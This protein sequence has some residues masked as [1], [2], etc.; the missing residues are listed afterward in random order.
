MLLSFILE[1][2]VIISYFFHFF[3]LLSQ[4]LLM[5]GQS[6]ESQDMLSQVIELLDSLPDASS[7]RIKQQ[8]MK[9][10]QAPPILVPK[11]NSLAVLG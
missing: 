6:T 4:Q 3:C 2:L 10:K 5:K 1:T 11:L 9:L 7:Q 8:I